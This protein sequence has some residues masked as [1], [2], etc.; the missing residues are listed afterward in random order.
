MLKDVLKDMHLGNFLL[1]LHH[2]YFNESNKSVNSFVCISMQLYFKVMQAR[3]ICKRVKHGGLRYPGRPSHLRRRQSVC[4]VPYV[5]AKGTF[6]YQEDG[7]GRLTTLFSKKNSKVS[8]SYIKLSLALN[9]TGK[10]YFQ[11]FLHNGNQVL[12]KQYCINHANHIR[13]NSGH[14]PQLHEGV[15]QQLSLPEGRQDDR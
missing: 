8:R 1:D 6:S 7:T 9:A 4:P 2:S 13:K 14:P 3:D 12:L 5:P 10:T 15:R 11:V